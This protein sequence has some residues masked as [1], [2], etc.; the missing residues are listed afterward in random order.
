MKARATNQ[1]TKQENNRRYF[2]HRHLKGNFHYI[3]KGRTIWTTEEQLTRSSPM[4]G[5]ALEELKNKFEYNVQFQ[6]PEHVV[7]QTVKLVPEKCA[8]KNRKMIYEILAIS[9]TFAD[10]KPLKGRW[11]KTLRVFISHTF[12]V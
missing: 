1:W 6:I 11:R 8:M 2:L 10:I 12:S 9:G 5:R 3:A 7:G 4:A